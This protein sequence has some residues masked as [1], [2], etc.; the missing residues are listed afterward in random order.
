MQ[1]NGSQWNLEQIGYMGWGASSISKE[2]NVQHETGFDPQPPC[3]NTGMVGKWVQAGLWA[4]WPVTTTYQQATGTSKRLC[5]KTQ[6]RQLLRNTCDWPL[7]S[8]QAS[9][10]D[11]MTELKEY[12][13]ETKALQT[14]EAL[15][16]FHSFSLRLWRTTV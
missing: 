15:V 4:H 14:Q 8:I 3:K 16:N 13:L 7:A 6:S 9:L 1:K 10:Y 2:H 11:T 5:L 12:K